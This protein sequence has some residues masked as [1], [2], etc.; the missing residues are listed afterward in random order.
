MQLLW[1]AATCSVGVQF[2]EGVEGV[3][4]VGGGWYR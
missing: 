2:W 4:G 1:T 3:M